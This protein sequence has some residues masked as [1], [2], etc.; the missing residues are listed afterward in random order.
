MKNETFCYS[1]LLTL[2]TAINNRNLLKDND[3]EKNVT[4]RGHEHELRCIFPA[5]SLWEVRKVSEEQRHIMLAIV[6]YETK[7]ITRGK[8]CYKRTV[9]VTCKNVIPYQCNAFKREMVSPLNSIHL[10]GRFRALV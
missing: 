5:E 3:C 8:Y 1:E 9:R 7:S 4:F 6:N 2:T 10:L